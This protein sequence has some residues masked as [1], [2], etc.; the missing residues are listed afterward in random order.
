MKKLF[1]TSLLFLILFSAFSAEYEEGIDTTS[2]ESKRFYFNTSSGIGIQFGILT[3]NFYKQYSYGDLYRVSWLTWETLPVYFDTVN[4]ST[5]Y[6]FANSCS[7]NIEAFFTFAFPAYT[8]SMED[9]DALKYDGKITDFSHH[10]NY[11]DSF[12]STGFYADYSFKSEFGVGIGFEYRSVSF[13]AENGYAQHT[14]DNGTSLQYWSAD[15]PHTSEYEG[16][17]VIAYDIFSYYWKAGIVWR[18]KFTNQFSVKLD[19]W[20]NLYRYNHILDKHYSFFPSNVPKVYFT[21]IVEVLFSGEE[22]RAN[23][24]YSISNNL[25]ISLIIM[26]KYLPDEH[27]PDYNGKPPN[28]T[29]NDGFKGGFKSWSASGVFAATFRL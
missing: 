25:S 1:I 8:G 20:I 15:M 22:I 27:G 21:D 7:V 4:L 24:E 16:N 19:A 3:E 5:G 26:G 13:H 12:K 2:N 11:T 10:D 18:H 6:K 9:F 28:L 14:S 29:L 17:T 23:F